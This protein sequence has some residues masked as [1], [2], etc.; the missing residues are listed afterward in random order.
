MNNMSIWNR[1]LGIVKEILCFYIIQPDNH[2]FS[3]IKNINIPNTVQLLHLIIIPYFGFQRIMSSQLKH[4]FHVF[5]YSFPYFRHIYP[6]LQCNTST[7]SLQ[8]RKHS[9]LLF[10][11]DI[12][13]DQISVCQFCLSAAGLTFHVSCNSQGAIYGL[14]VS[15]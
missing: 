14:G 4:H 6:T 12:K 2:Q 1:I 5:Q 13:Q 10:T 7:H 9:M 15:L 8:A 3:A 11:F